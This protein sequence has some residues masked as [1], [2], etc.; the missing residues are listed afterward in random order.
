MNT[1]GLIGLSILCLTLSF[2]G[3]IY[4]LQNKFSELEKE[5]SILKQI[6][7]YDIHKNNKQDEGRE[8]IY[9]D[10]ETNKIIKTEKYPTFSK[11]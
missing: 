10:N 6:I 4:F 7:I 9:F 5:I 2:F 1:N 3:T 8:V 11:K